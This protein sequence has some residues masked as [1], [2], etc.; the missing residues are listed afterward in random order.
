ML[1]LGGRWPD[2]CEPAAG[3]HEGKLATV[4]FPYAGTESGGARRRERSTAVRYMR[5]RVPGSMTHWR[6]TA[7]RRTACAQ[8]QLLAQGQMDRARAGRVVCRRGGVTLSG[9]SDARGEWERH[10]A[11]S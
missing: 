4:A 6:G 11:W 5:S 10:L 9:K 8:I 3:A 2:G 7:P 1:G